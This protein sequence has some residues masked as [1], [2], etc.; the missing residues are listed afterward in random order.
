LDFGHVVVLATIHAVRAPDQSPTVMVPGSAPL[1]RNA[2]RDR[3][4]GFVP[5]TN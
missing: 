1:S 5:D 3:W 4:P 2:R